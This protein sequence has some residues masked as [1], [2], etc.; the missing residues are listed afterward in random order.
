ME[1]NLTEKDTRISCEPFFDT[2]ARY[3]EDFPPETVRLL[4]GFEDPT[5][6]KCRAIEQFINNPSVEV[7]AELLRKKVGIHACMVHY[8]S[9]CVERYEY[10]NIYRARTALWYACEQGNDAKTAWLLE[11]GADVN[12]GEYINDSHGWEPVEIRSAA[13]AAV[14]GKSLDCFRLL[15]QTGKIKEPFTKF[16][17]YAVDCKALE[18]VR[19]LMEEKNVPWDESLWEEAVYSSDL[20]KYLIDQRHLSWG[21][22]VWKMALSPDR[23]KVLAFL[24]ERGAVVETEDL[25]NA[26]ESDVSLL[27]FL[28][29]HARQDIN[30]RNENGQTLL[31]WAARLGDEKMFEMLLKAGADITLKDNQGRDVYQFTSEKSAAGREWTEQKIARLKEAAARVQ[32]Q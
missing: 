18:V 7:C 2:T 4:D 11:Q 1:E 13:W 16:L 30:V 5:D 10:Q 14:E 12:F 8:S 6:E 21:R 20:M 31:F 29:K 22:D 25:F 27:K 24:L 26:V 17:S 23:T 3:L 15:A 9:V 19:F 32:A 28:L